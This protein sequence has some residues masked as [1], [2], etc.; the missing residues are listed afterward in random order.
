MELAAVCN[1][2]QFNLENVTM[3]ST[4]KQSKSIEISKDMVLILQIYR[5][6]EK[7]EREEYSVFL[8]KKEGWRTYQGRYKAIVIKR[9]KASPSIRWDYD[10]GARRDFFLW[11]ELAEAL[12]DW[13]HLSHRQDHNSDR[14]Q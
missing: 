8:R 13:D 3:N 5:I 4:L 6:Y 14:L 2:R 1:K 9:N 12:R 10:R 11:R 7:K